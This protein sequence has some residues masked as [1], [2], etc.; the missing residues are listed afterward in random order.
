MNPRLSMLLA[1]RRLSQH[2]VQS[3]VTLLGVAL[4]LTVVA[5]ILIV[6]RNSSESRIQSQA[7]ADL[8]KV[9]RTLKNGEISPPP[10]RILKVSF[11]R[12]GEPLAQPA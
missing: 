5:A 10:K 4:G 6:D 11:E 2:P 9:G 1:W 12:Q 3:T 8:S 7:L